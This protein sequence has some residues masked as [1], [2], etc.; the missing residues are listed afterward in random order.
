MPAY[1]EA[2]GIARELDAILSY[3]ERRP[4]S[5]EVIVSA[6]GDDGTRER[7]QGCARGDRRVV[8]TGTVVRRGK[9]RAVR[10]AAAL[11]SGR[12]IGYVDADGK[13]PIE[14]LDRVLP[15]LERDC[16]VALGSRGLPESRVECRRPLHRRCGSRIFAALVHG[17]VGLRDVRDTQCGFKFFRREAARELFARQR[18]DGYL[19]DVELLCLARALGYRVR[20]VPIR[21][22]DDGDSRLDLVSGGLP[23][24]RELWR[25]RATHHGAPQRV[26]ESSPAS[27]VSPARR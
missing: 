3:L 21:W 27:T 22:R 9:G 4:Y 19:F 18:T 11:A 16:D 26:I 10:E 7:A 23:L 15:W 1:D 13:V 12:V 17:L 25:I 2:A 8:V 14:E 6:D 20:E 24:L 5:F